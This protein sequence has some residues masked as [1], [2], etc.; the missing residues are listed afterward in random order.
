MTAKSEHLDIIRSL[1]CACC[2]ASPP[3]SAHHPR[4]GAGMAQKASDWLAIPLC[5]ECHQGQKGIHGDRSRAKLRDKDEIGMLGETN[6]AVASLYRVREAGE[7]RVRSRL[8]G[9][10]AEAGDLGMPG[11][12]GTGSQEGGGIDAFGGEVYLVTTSG[13]RVVLEVHPDEVNQFLGYPPGTR[14][15]LAAAPIDAE[16]VRSKSQWIAEGMAAIRMAAATE[17]VGAAHA[18]CRSPQFAEW[19]KTFGKLPDEFVLEYC[20]IE[21]RRDLRHDRSAQG[22]FDHMLQ[23]FSRWLN[24]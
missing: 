7:V 18:I 9:E 12:Q 20:G 6:A 2:G 21:S 16:P 19:T 11:A 24:R 13:H 14:F 10:E 23:R 1:P 3:S 17:P 4:H 22:M 15:A 5:W 8:A